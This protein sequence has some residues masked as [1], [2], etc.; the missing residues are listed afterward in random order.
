MAPGA[1]EVRR[2]L[3]HVSRSH[4]LLAHRRATGTPPDYAFVVPTLGVGFAPSHGHVLLLDTAREVGGLV[5]GGDTCS[6]PPLVCLLLA[7][8]KLSPAFAPSGLPQYH[9]T[10]DASEGPETGGAGGSANT[11]RGL[12]VG[13][14]MQLKPAVGASSV[15]V[16]PMCWCDDKKPPPIL[17]L[18]ALI[19]HPRPLLLHSPQLLTT[20]RKVL[21]DVTSTAV[22]AATAELGAL[23]PAMAAE[24]TSEQRTSRKRQRQQTERQQQGAPAPRLE[25]LRRA[26]RVAHNRLDEWQAF[27]G[28]ADFIEFARQQGV[29]ASTLAVLRKLFAM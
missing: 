27:N 9:G 19:H 22:V 11:S 10:V 5:P 1:L 17:A 23:E 25:E 13:T 20:A 8:A 12:L 15:G 2:R 18:R 21:G 16:W 29:D 28:A 14:A 6:A 3:T 24:P 4:A 26:R 7:W